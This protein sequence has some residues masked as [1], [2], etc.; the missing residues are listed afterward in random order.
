MSDLRSV[1]AHRT[2]PF[3]FLKEKREEKKHQVV[4]G[5][6][7]SFATQAVPGERD[8]KSTSHQDAGFL[9]QKKEVDVASRIKSI[10]VVH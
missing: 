5:K 8:F 4:V 6:P 7:A 1:L 9:G 10:K 3:P 2:F